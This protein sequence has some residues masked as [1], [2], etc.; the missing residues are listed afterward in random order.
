[1]RRP[2]IRGT[3][4]GPE[5]RGYEDGVLDICAFVPFTRFDDDITDWQVFGQ[6]DGGQGDEVGDDGHQVY[7]V[8]D[9]PAELHFTGARKESH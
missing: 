3:R 4:F 6:V 7:H 9:V 5:K 8:H 1:M 2:Y